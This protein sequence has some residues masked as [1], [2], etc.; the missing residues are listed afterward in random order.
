[1]IDEIETTEFASPW[2]RKAVLKGARFKRIR[3]SGP[4]P[5]W[6]APSSKGCESVRRCRCYSFQDEVHKT[7]LDLEQQI[8]ERCSPPDALAAAVV[9]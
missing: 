4:L 6:V 3:S 5:Q 9:R 1:M 2:F 8:G 7:V